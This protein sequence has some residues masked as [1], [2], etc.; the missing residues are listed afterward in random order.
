[1]PRIFLSAPDVGELESQ[2]VLEALS[3]GWVAP[4]GPDLAAFEAELAA[5]V[6][7]AHGVALSS[8]TAALHLGLLVLGVRRNDIVLTST[9]TFAA[10][11]NAIIYTGAVPFFVDSERATGNVDV[12]L[13]WEAAL[14]VRRSGRRIG[15]I[16]PVDLLGACA[17]MDAITDL[18]A[19]LEVPLLVDAAESVG[20]TYRG[21]PAGSFGAASV[22]S[23]NLDPPPEL[24]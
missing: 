15:A 24:V 3:S 18:A 17:D 21:R 11:A 23:F 5:R 4:A 8:G 20:A 10:T 7:V 13:L 6:G 22:V 12:A 14:S 2:Y 19:E 16:V 1:M 9:M